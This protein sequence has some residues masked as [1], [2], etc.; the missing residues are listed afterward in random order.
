MK[1][2]RERLY[3]KGIKGNRERDEKGRQH[4]RREGKNTFCQLSGSVSSS[5]LNL[6]S[7][8]GGT[9]DTPE[10]IQGLNIFSCR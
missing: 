3:H 2:D 7:P 9:P 6:H 10:F 4:Q 8:A 1:S 5:L